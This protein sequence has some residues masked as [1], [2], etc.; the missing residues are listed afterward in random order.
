MTFSNS[1][2]VLAS[3]FHFCHL[4]A[5]SN[6]CF[7]FKD[8]LISLNSVASARSMLPMIASASSSN[9]ASSSFLLFVSGTDRRTSAANSR[10]PTS[11]ANSSNNFL[12]VIEPVLLISKQV[13]AR[14]WRSRKTNLPEKCK[15]RTRRG[16]CQLLST[17]AIPMPCKKAGWIKAVWTSFF[18]ITKCEESSPPGSRM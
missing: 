14:N 7:F 10:P 11:Y 4:T 12:R 9:S 15:R 6:F 17:P 5:T 1:D 3:F 18:F 13:V 2:P 16:S 8:S